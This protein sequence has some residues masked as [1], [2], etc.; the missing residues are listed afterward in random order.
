MLVSNDFEIQK[1]LMNSGNY[2]LMLVN[3]NGVTDSNYYPIRL[4]KD[5]YP[6]INVEANFDSTNNLFVY[7]GSAFDDYQISDIKIKYLKNEKIVNETSLKINKQREEFF[8]YKINTNEISEFEYDKLYFEVWDNDGVNGFKSAKTEVFNLNSTSKTD[9]IANRNQKNN[10]LKSAMQSSFETIQEMNE[11]IEKIKRSLINN[12]KLDWNQKENVKDL[13]KKQMKLENEI[14]K[15]KDLLNDLIEKNE[16]LSPEIIEK[17]KLLNEMMEKVFDEE[18]LKMIDE[19]QKDFENLD[20]DEIKKLLENLED[21][22]LNIQEELDREIE[23]FKQMEIEQRLTE[24]NKKIKDIK[25]KQDSLTNNKNIDQNSI[26]KQND[27]KKEFDELK[28]DI[29]EMQNLNDSLEN[30]NNFENTEELEKKIDESLDESIKKM[31]L[32]NKKSSKKSQKNTSD[33]MQDL[34]DQLSMMLSSCKGNQNFENLETLRQIL[35]NLISISFSQEELIIKTKETNKNSSE[36]IQIIR[37]QKKIKDDSE[38]VKDSLLALSKRV[39][40]IESIVNKEINKINNYLSKSINSLEDRDI[41][42][43]NISQQFVMTSANNLALL[44][45]ESLKQMQK[46]LSSQTPG[47]K[48]CNN[49]GSGPPSLSQLKQMQ[50]KL[51]EEMKNGENGK[52]GSKSLGESLSKKLMQLAQLQQEAKENLLKMRDEL[53]KGKNKGDIDKLL[54]DMEKN[55][56]DIIFNKISQKTIDRQNKILSRLLDF[57]EAEREQG[58]DDKR[59]SLEWI[60]K[61]DIETIDEE[62]SR[63]KKKNISE[64]ILNRNNVKLNP[65]YKRIS[66][67]YFNKISKDD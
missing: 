51:L 7:N 14:Q 52:N 19:M 36:F 9:A 16:I 27:I 47:N 24:L 61:N 64:E 53:G 65:F 42:K 13:L 46:Q 10:E 35:E 1:T 31:K 34:E 45:D 66:T 57:D 43:A 17:Q 60:M 50:K 26:D 38:I 11:E 15:S 20:K 8:D 30:P 56:D 18:L 44:L 40:E 48:Q 39:I 28:K 21:Q 41:R 6:K 29:D 5:E 58:E 32:G 3:K 63:Q 55:N 25:S 2:K 23:L 59:E 33:K 12:K 22:N 4:L 49:P 37:A 67:D 54:D 62:I